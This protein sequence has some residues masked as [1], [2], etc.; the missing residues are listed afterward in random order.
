MRINRSIVFFLSLFGASLNIEAQDI[1]SLPDDPAIV[2]GVLP[3]GV[4]YFL[5]REEHRNGFADISLVQKGR[6]DLETA[7][8]D[9]R[10]IS[11]Y[12]SGKGVGYRD[13]DPLSMEGGSMILSFNSVPGL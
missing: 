1:P 11:A 2:R 5:A 3:S 6:T 8:S 9:S 10:E 13:G 7:R 4:E 12:M